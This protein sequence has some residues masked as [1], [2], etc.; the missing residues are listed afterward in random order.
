MNFGLVVHS[1]IGFFL[2]HVIAWAFS[3]NRRTVAWRPVAA[4]MLL[5]FGLGLLLLKA[6]YARDVFLV[7]NDALNALEKA[8]QDGAA[9]VFGFLGGGPLPFVETYPGASFVLAFRALPLV[10]V[11]SA[12]SALLFYW[13]VLP[14]IVKAFSVLLQKTMGVGGAIGLSSA[15]NVF[16]GMVEAPLIVKP[17]IRNMSRGELFILMSCG[18]ATVAGTVMALYA[19][20]LSKVVPD[21]LGHILIASII[22][23]PAAIAISVLMVPV[24]AKALATEGN[25][26][27]QAATS[28][29]D[30]VTRGTVD[31]VQLLI[32]IVAMLLVLV[33]LVSL[34]NQILALLPQVAGAPVT[35][36]RALGIAMAPL[37]WIMGIPW[38]EAATAGALMGTKTV[39]NEL[40]AY[41]DLAKLPE[42]A[43][44]ARSRLMMTYALC[45]FANF[46]S[47]GIM[48]GGLAT[49]APE[50]RDEIV[51]LGGKTIVS[52]TL[53]TCV[54][55]SVVGMLY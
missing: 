42:G 6:P 15:A 51:S 27:P 18:M 33:A 31:G 53:A 14:W 48:I 44:S 22:S 39:L 29:M 25:L 5:T 41:I 46:G 40:L 52:G 26:V 36:Q 2:L 50:R 47:L 32:N 20:I 55:G 23:T 7:L 34:A 10:L 28:S 43:L 35:L 45:G 17:Y 8:T 3:E 9:F 21:A 4:G 24:P 1:L 12:L 30:A 11:V 49:M 54:A 13:R 38:S 37:V 16:V 19:S